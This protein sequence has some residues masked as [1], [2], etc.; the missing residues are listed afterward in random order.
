MS[1]QA[2][3][4]QIP[5]PHHEAHIDLG[6]Y[7]KSSVYGGLDGVINTLTIIAG[8]IASGAAPTYILAVGLS[9]I[10]GDGLGMGFGDYLSA[11]AE[12]EFIR[13][14]E[15]RQF[16]EVEHRLE[17]EKLQIVEIYTKKGY[18]PQQSK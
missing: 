17:D 1:S 12:K 10:I 7:L 14:E 16:W 15:Q 8:G 6:E 4:S 18:E 5:T 13:T 3:N 9:V 11:K 2:I